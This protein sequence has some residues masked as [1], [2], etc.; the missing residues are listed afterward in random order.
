VNDFIHPI[1]ADERHRSEKDIKARFANVFNVEFSL[2]INKIY[3]RNED[4][5]EKSVNL[6]LPQFQIDPSFIPK[7]KVSNELQRFRE[8]VRNQAPML[9]SQWTEAIF[10]PNKPS[11]MAPST[12]GRMLYIPG[13]I[14]FCLTDG[15]EKKIWLEKIAGLKRNYRVTIIIDS[16]YSCFSDLMFAHSVQTLFGF[17]RMLSQIDIPYFDLIVTTAGA[18]KILA[19]NQNTQ[20]AIDFQTFELFGSLLSTLMENE[21]GS[22]LADALLVALK[23]KSLAPAKRS[24]LFV[25]TDG[26]FPTPMKDHLRNILRLCRQSLVEVFGIGIGRY[27]AG[28]FAIFAKCVWSLNPRFLVTAISGFFGNDIPKTGDRIDLFAPVAANSSVIETLFTRIIDKWEDI[29]VFKDL[30]KELRDQTLFPQSIPPFQS[31]DGGLNN[32]GITNPAFTAEKAMYAKGTFA[33]QKILVCCFWS[34]TIAGPNESEWVDPRYLTSRYPGSNYCVQDVL[35]HYGIT[36]DVVQNYK[37][38][39][40]KLQTGQYYAVWVIC[41]SGKGK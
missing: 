31:E 22:N 28:A 14:K 15:Q 30:F 16:S 29:C 25:L 36:L 37:D 23:L 34:K 10:V 3:L 33:G 13:L 21:C 35:N 11:Q 32:P 40:L 17:L 5:H 9:E 41:G 26:L 8:T 19:I 38:G 18:P 2:Q 12:K 39:M 4:D 27:P 1:S 6:R 7:L 24:Y 20:R